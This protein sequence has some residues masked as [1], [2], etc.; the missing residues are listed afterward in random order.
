MLFSFVG[1]VSCPAAPNPA[2]CDDVSSFVG[3]VAPRP[4]IA[5][6]ASPSP[7]VPAHPGPAPAAKSPDAPVPHIGSA[8]AKDNFLTDGTLLNHTY[9]ITLRDSNTEKDPDGSRKKVPLGQGGFGITYLAVDEHLGR[10][11][12]IKENFPQKIAVHR[13]DLSIVSTMATR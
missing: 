9:R 4:D 2:Q 8:P 11:V 1:A 6:P 12:M 13:S 10:R 7:A 3:A 5:E